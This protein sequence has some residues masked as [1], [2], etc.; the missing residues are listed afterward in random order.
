[1]D[2]VRINS[3]LCPFKKKPKLIFSRF[4]FVVV[5]L[6]NHN[7]VHSHEQNV[8]IAYF[9]TRKKKNSTIKEVKKNVQY[10]YGI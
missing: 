2:L 7:I 8:G 10:H 3:L 1:M 5:T 6:F 9:V 4:G